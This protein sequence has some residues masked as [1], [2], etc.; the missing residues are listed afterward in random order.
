MGIQNFGVIPLK[1][2]YQYFKKL[3][4]MTYCLA[5]FYIYLSATSIILILA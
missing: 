5:N 4:F 2:E 3:N 1:K